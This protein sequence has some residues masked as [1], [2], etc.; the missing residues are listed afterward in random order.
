MFFLP[1]CF[2]LLSLC[3][4]L[5]RRLSAFPSVGFIFCFLL[6]GLIRGSFSPLIVCSVIPK[7]FNRESKCFYRGGLSA[8]LFTLTLALSREG[9]G[10]KELREKGR[11]IAPSIVPRDNGKGGT[12]KW[13]LRASYSRLAWQSPGG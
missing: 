4:C 2:L 1:Q 10:E 3:F 12:P 9:R 8:L 6:G 11:E 7:I 13:S 5:R